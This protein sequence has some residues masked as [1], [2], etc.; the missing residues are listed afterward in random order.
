MTRRIPAFLSFDI[1]P[2]GFQASTGP[3]WSGAE[4]LLARVPA[5]RDRLAAVSG[6]VPVFGWYLRMDPQVGALYGDAAFAAHEFEGRLDLMAENGDVLG[7]HVHPLRWSEP[8]R[9]WIH[10][11]ADRGWMT[12][13]IESSVAAFADCYGEAPVRY[14]HG[15]G[16]L[17]NH[18]ISTV[19]S[20]D[21][22]VDLSL[23]PVAGWALRSKWVASGVDRSPLYADAVDC[24]SAPLEVYRPSAADFRVDDGP[25]GRQ[26]V[27]VPMS[28]TRWRPREPWRHRVRRR[29]RA[30]DRR[31]RTQMLYPSQPWP[32]PSFF[33]DLVE[34][35]L[36]TMTRPHLSL[37]IR[38]DAPF[39]LE[40]QRSDAVLDALPEHPLAKRL[41]FV[42]P[43]DI[44]SATPQ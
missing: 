8:A 26:L 32:S 21:V 43:I 1:E 28:V 19:E 24:S 40:A 4:H 10:D 18:V 13:C 31:A 41:Q 7:L 44:A 36:G 39:S 16:V 29:S 12:E 35:Q 30:S 27:M 11:C 6:D 3:G 38:T 37:G 15:A 9:L 23:E 5:L 14:R 22:R 20:L 34:R 33:W 17:T 2:D 42:D 25:A